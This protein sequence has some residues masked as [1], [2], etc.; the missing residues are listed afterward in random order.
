MESATVSDVRADPGSLTASFTIDYV[1]TS[2][3]TTTQQGRLQLQ[4][5]GDG[6]LIAAEG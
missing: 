1:S 4:R 6:Y 2:G 5:S 3:R